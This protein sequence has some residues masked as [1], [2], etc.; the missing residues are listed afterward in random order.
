MFT[1]QWVSKNVQYQLK[2]VSFSTTLTFVL[3]CIFLLLFISYLFHICDY[4]LSIMGTYYGYLSWVLK[5]S[6]THILSLS[7]GIKPKETLYMV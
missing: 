3:Q 4:Y 6:S 7:L 1:A 2:N 5:Y